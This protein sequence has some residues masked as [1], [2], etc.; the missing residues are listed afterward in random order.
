[1]LDEATG[2]SQD[3]VLFGCV[4]REGEAGENRNERLH[5][6]IPGDAETRMAIY[7]GLLGVDG[8]CV[9]PGTARDRKISHSNAV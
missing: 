7:C 3:V 4:S 1:M 9:I 8:S 6:T 5:W 2:L